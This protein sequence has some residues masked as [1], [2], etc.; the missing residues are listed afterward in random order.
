MVFSNEFLQPRQSFDSRDRMV[1]HLVEG[2]SFGLR[3]D[4]NDVA[5]HA[6]Y[7]LQIPY[8]MNTRADCSIRSHE[9][10]V[11]PMILDAPTICSPIET[12]TRFLGPRVCEITLIV[13][14]LPLTSSVMV[15]FFKGPVDE[16]IQP[17]QEDEAEPGTF[18][19]SG[20][21]SDLR[22]FAVDPVLGVQLPVAVLS[23]SAIKVTASQL[24][25][26]LH[27]HK[28]EVSRGESIPEDLQVTL[29]CHL[30]GDYF[31]LGVTRSWEPLLEPYKC[32]LLYE[33]SKHRG[34][35]MSLNADCPLHLNL[36]GALLLIVDEVF[37][38]FTRMIKEVFGQEDTEMERVAPRSSHLRD[39]ITVGERVRLRGDRHLAVIHDIPKPL[40]GDRVAFAFCNLTGQKVRI[41]QQQNFDRISGLKP[42]IVTYLNH[43]ESTSLSLDATISVVKNLSVVEVPYPGLP[44]SQSMRRAK[45]ASKHAVDIQIPGF[46]WVQ[47]I[48]VDTFG[49]KFES[50]QPRSPD[51]LGKVNQDWRLDNA[52]QLLVEVGLDNGGRLVTVR[53]LFEV[54]NNT[55]HPLSVLLHPNPQ[56]NPENSSAEAGSTAVDAVSVVP[57]GEFCQIPTM[58]LEGSLH[59]GGCHLGSLWL[60]P[61]SYGDISIPSLTPVVGHEGA[62]ETDFETRFC[63]RPVQLA[64]LVAESAELFAEHGK[65]EIAPEKAKTGVQIACGVK[66]KSGEQLAPFCYAVEVGRSPIVP[67]K[68]NTSLIGGTNRYEYPEVHA[69]VSYT[70]SIHAPYVITNL[71][72]ETGRFELMHA[73]RRTV[74]WY[75]DLKPGQSMPVHSVGL[76]APLLLL[77]NLGFCRTP[78][79]EGA[80]VHHG[81][82][83]VA[84]NKGKP[85]WIPIP[86]PP[87][88]QFP[89]VSVFCALDSLTSLFSLSV[90]QMVSD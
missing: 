41:H 20:D 25:N 63:S 66:S 11:M 26:G 6:D 36:S 15:N 9:L 13:E 30:W 43:D 10:N 16:N 18:S 4:G 53:S 2:L 74:L 67:E 45:R 1:R 5:N 34:Q 52:M 42:A 46:K 86:I 61:A 62:G 75:G 21:I 85:F 19:F 23:I 37:D 56:H 8:D 79:G 33:K 55:T 27:L 90:A 71:L 83:F 40:Q 24:S 7:A 64:K 80:L 47:G 81:A 44:N 60:K 17:Q 65:T 50:L 70:L 87:P 48:K 49:R 29:D 77:L 72:P 89:C 68:R 54:R 58:L 32:R 76:D 84:T 38:S 88:P 39:R 3:L 14:V 57:P 73:I 51:V 28:R 69:P 22:L 78:V 35:G 12:P 82:D 59:M 31:K